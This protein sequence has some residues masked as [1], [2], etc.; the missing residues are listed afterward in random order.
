MCAF[1]D[2][3]VVDD[4]L[5]M[6]NKRINSINIYVPASSWFFLL[7]MILHFFYVKNLLFLLLFIINFWVK[8]MHFRPLSCTFPSH[9]WLIQL[10]SA[11]FFIC[12]PFHRSIMCHMKSFYIDFSCLTWIFMFYV[13]CCILHRKSDEMMRTVR[14][15]K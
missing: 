10:L 7:I 11:T 6:H 5:Y 9:L 4:W 15:R 1:V 3:R 13:L 12:L 14:M 2:E 8:K